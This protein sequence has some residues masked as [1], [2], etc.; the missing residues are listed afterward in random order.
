VGRATYQ[1]PHGPALGV[2]AH[3]DHNAGCRG[4][5]SYQ[6]RMESPEAKKNDAAD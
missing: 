2:G 4:K 5:N 1:G 3:V 6:R